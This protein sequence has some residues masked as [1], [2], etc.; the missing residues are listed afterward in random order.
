MADLPFP[1]T[2]DTIRELIRIIFEERVGGINAFD[3]IA[4]SWRHPDYPTYIDG[5]MIYQGSAMDFGDV[6]DLEGLIYYGAGR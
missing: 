1:I 3:E 4:Y 6:E 2:G 5:S